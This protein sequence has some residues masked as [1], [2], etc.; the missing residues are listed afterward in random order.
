MM[1][2]MTGTAVVALTT[3]AIRLRSSICPPRSQSAEYPS[4][5]IA[6]ASSRWLP[7]A[8]I[9]TVIPMGPRSSLLIAP[10]PLP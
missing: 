7:S 5:S 6:A 4:S 10:H 2:G 9:S 3:S 8:E 1:P